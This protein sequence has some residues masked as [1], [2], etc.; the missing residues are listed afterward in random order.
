MPTTTTT[1]SFNKPVVGAD[2]D[3][4]GGYL[5]GNWDSVDD[6]LDGTTPVTG[7]DI[8][9]GTLDGITSFSMSS[10]NATF[11]DN[12]KAIFGAGNDLEI[13]HNG[14]ENVIDSNV[15]TLVL[16]SAGA[17]TIE[18]RD[19]SSQVLAQFNDNADV[20]LFYNNNEKLATTSTGVDITGD[21]TLGDSNPT[22]TFNDSSVSNLSHAVR[23]ASDNLQIAVDINGVD[24]G[25][26]VEIFDGA[27]EVA[28]FSAGA[29][30]ITGTLTS[31]GLTVEAGANTQT[32][33][34]NADD[35]VIKNSGAAGLSIFGGD[36]NSQNIYFG[37]PTQQTIAR[38]DARYNS[39]AEQL[40]FHVG[41]DNKPKLL[42]DDT[43]DISFYEDTG[44]TPK[45]FWDASAES[46][47]LSNSAGTDYNNG[48]LKIGSGEGVGD[49]LLT[50]G[51]NSAGE[52]SYL[53]A[54]K[55]GN[56]YNSLSLNPNG[57]NVGIG[58]SSP[59]VPLH[60]NGRVRVDGG[61]NDL[62]LYHNGSV[63]Y[64]E[65]TGGSATPI[66]FANSGSERMRIDSSGYIT[67]TA[68]NPQISF[69]DSANSS[70]KWSIQNTSSAIRFYDNTAA[71]ERMRIDSSGNVGIGTSSPSY[72][73]DVSQA[74]GGNI[75]R[76]SYTGG[77]L[78]P[79]IALSA[80]SDA[81]MQIVSGNSNNT[82]GLGINVNGSEAMRIDSS[83]NLLV[84]TTNP[85]YSSD[86]IAIVPTASNGTGIGIAVGNFNSK[87]IGIYNG[88][89]ATGTAT[90]I[91]FQD[92]VSVTRG[93]ITVTTSATA[94]NTSSDYRLKEDVQPMT[95]ASDRV[96]ALKP[97][98]FAWKA[99]GSRVDGFL[100]HEAQ[101][102]VPES[103][104]GVKDAMREEEYE[105]TPAILD[106]DGNVVT[107][108]VMG[109][110]QVPDYQG[111]D[112][113]KLVPLLT[114]AL[115]EALTKIDA[116]ETRIAT[117]EGTA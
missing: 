25:S 47:V 110:R 6:L 42:I 13:S 81:L 63:A 20:K 75:V 89:T 24:A 61:S 87:G 46:L 103:V 44:T 39:G 96:M 58:T 91:E 106:E 99:D 30:D 108:A 57:G 101:E 80:N 64:I 43:G 117:L 22:I 33:L 18:M 10:G 94:Y 95:G 59:S 37:S 104:T 69:V 70:Y 102:V 28:R 65:T 109:T 92:H 56:Q 23:S 7:I 67:S 111:I 36:A 98:N 116:L 90:A 15:G 32:A 41:A 83:G 26:R 12:S 48:A 107:E 53:Q 50:L 115:Q 73:A 93:S 34:G 19:Q 5:N 79:Y 1:Y 21:I 113:S 3:D 31:D 84:G 68:S 11:A 62:D 29:V 38:L 51:T 35:L 49:R 97:C 100:A 78:N 105:V 16:R 17:G 54:V 88:Y 74:S 2:E 55:I 86:K 114:A 85:A 14:S 4:W 76:A 72:K 112:Q 45:F 82:V 71:T 9:S 60:V 66:G 77:A 40:Y 52:Y 8:N 27:T